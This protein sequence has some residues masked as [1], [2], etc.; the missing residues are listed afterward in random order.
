MAARQM[1]QVLDSEAT[2]TAKRVRILVVKRRLDAMTQ[3][4]Y[5]FCRKQAV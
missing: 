3:A 1:R 2:A 4:N 5:D